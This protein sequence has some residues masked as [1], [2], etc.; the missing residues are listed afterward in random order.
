MYISILSI[1]CRPIVELT[2]LNY[3]GDIRDQLEKLS[4][5]RHGTY[6]AVGDSLPSLRCS[7]VSLHLFDYWSGRESHGLDGRLG[8]C[9]RGEK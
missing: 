9:P 7:L 4:L 2:R 5:C 6:V 1:L 8:E 3:I